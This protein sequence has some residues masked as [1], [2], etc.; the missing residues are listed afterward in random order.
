M[1]TGQL[2]RLE[3]VQE[4]WLQDKAGALSIERRGPGGNVAPLKEGLDLCSL[5]KEAYQDSE[6]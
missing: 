2:A 3:G 6:F 4:K 5:V 1:S